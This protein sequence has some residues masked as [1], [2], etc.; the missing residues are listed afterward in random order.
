[1]YFRIQKEN[2][3]NGSISNSNFHFAYISIIIIIYLLPLV[4]ITFKCFFIYEHLHCNNNKYCPNP[5]NH[6][7]TKLI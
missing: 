4:I 1:M 2:N 5:N 6:I 3:I 7:Q